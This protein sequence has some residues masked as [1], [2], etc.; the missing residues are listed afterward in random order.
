M[1]ISAVLQLQVYFGLL[2]RNSGAFFFWAGSL[3]F[4]QIRQ[5]RSLLGLL[6]LSALFICFVS[7]HRSESLTLRLDLTERL[8]SSQQLSTYF[9]HKAI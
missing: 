4:L 6:C 7:A 5:W 8:S 3:E 1:S 9:I 2:K